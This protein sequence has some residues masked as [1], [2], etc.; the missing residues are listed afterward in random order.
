MQQC[1]KLH[2]EI[3][4]ISVADVLRASKDRIFPARI[5]LVKGNNRNTRTR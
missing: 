3:G 2:K 1:E 4:M 5:Y